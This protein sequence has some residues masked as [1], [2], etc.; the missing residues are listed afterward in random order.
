MF[1]HDMEFIRNRWL[2]RQLEAALKALPVVVVTGARQT[3]K[4]T[5]AQILPRL[6]AR[7]DAFPVSAIVAGAR[8]CRA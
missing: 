7:A 4:T 1:I 5:L 8:P 3:G 2:T 6:L